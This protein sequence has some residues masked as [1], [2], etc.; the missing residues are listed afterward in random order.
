MHSENRHCGKRLAAIAAIPLRT[1]KLYILRTTISANASRGKRLAAFALHSENHHCGKR[2]ARQT[3]LRF[4]GKPYPNA[5]NLHSD[6]QPLWQTP[7]R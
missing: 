7:R 2:L 1:A 3:L 6:N 4:C 5:Q